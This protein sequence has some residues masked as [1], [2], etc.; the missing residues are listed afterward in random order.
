MES[1]KIGMIVMLVSLAEKIKES[2][3]GIRNLIGTYKEWLKTS[4]NLECLE[5]DIIIPQFRVLKNFIP[6]KFH[7]EIIR[8]NIKYSHVYKGGVINSSPERT[9]R[10]TKTMNDLSPSVD[11]SLG[12]ILMS[13]SDPINIP[14]PPDINPE[15]ITS[16]PVPISKKKKQ[17]KTGSHS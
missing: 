12:A 7:T 15:T 9:I 2:L 4:S 1:R 5:Q 3:T 14:K 17:N 8:S 13:K 10:Q 6:E 11:E 16:D